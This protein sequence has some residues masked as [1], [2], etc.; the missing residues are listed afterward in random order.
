LSCLRQISTARQL[1]S[2]RVA[3]P[4]A[5]SPNLRS[6]L[7]L[8]AIRRKTIIQLRRSQCTQRAP[9]SVTESQLRAAIQIPS[10]FTHGKKPP[11]ILVPGTGSTGCF[12]FTGN[13]IPLLAQRSYADPVW[14]N[15]PDY[16][17]DDAQVNSVRALSFLPLLSPD[18]GPFRNTSH[19]QSTTSRPFLR[20]A[21]C[22]S[23]PGRKAA[24]TRNGH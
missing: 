14:L 10:S 3:Y 2:L 19:M 22:L 24:L 23:F 16:M 1:R 5:T 9:Y 11:V 7:S 20:T 17:L 21:T 4:R 13:F 15:I 6:C 8:D 12:S 18:F